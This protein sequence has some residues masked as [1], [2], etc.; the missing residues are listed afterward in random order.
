MERKESRQEGTSPVGFWRRLDMIGK[1]AM[2]IVGSGLGLLALSPLFAG[3][4]IWIKLDSKGPVF[5]LQKRIGKGQKEFDLYKFRSMRSNSDKGCLLT[6]GGHDP[7]VTKVGY[8]IRKYKIDELPQL[9][10]VF[11]GDMS[12]VGP[13]PQ[14]RRYVN[15]YTPEQLKVLEVRPGM[16]DPASIYYR[17]ESE[18]LAQHDDPEAYYIKYIMPHKLGLCQRYIDKRNIW[19]DLKIILQTFGAVATDVPDDSDTQ[20]SA[21]NSK[22][23]EVGKRRREKVKSKV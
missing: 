20:S 18:I 1:R 8:F 12:L 9:I 19:T 5:Y 3:V 13:R 17:N 15:Y 16:T 21:N 10:N 7:R 23:K 22:D 11:K 4:A 2:D 6:I 14:V